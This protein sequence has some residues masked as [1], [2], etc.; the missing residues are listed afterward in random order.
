PTSTAGIGKSPKEDVYD[1]IIDDLKS[2]STTL[3]SKT[4]EQKGRAT[5]EAAIAMLG[6]VYLYIEEY[7]LALAEFVKLNGKFDLE[8]DF[9]DN[10]KDDK[11]F[12][13]E[14]IFE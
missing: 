8:P 2:A 5:S 9:Y 7:E 11:E 14:S 6:K 3:L 13:I 10:F 1:L 12:G 4:V